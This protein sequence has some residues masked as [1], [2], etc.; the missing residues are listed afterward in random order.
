MCC[1]RPLRKD[2]TWVPAL[3][4]TKVEV[5]DRQGTRR[6]PHNKR[7][8]DMLYA[9]NVASVHRL[10]AVHSLYAWLTLHSLA[11]ELDK[12]EKTDVQNVTSQPSFPTGTSVPARLLRL[13]WIA[14]RRPMLLRRE[15][16]LIRQ[17]HVLG[18]GVRRC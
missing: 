10:G 12:Q 3:L 1:S 15:F 7:R 5:L 8:M 4:D 14:C 13:I 16:T 2:C 11:G 17:A 6:A 18:G 9:Q